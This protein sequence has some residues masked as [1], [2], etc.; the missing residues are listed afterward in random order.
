M[1]GEEIS[2]AGKGKNPEHQP[3]RRGQQQATTCSLGLFP[4]TGQCPQATTVDEFQ[5]RQVQDDVGVAGHHTRER[6][7]DAAA[8]VASSCPRNLTTV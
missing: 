8:S 2:Q 7:S 1:D 4:H 3:L 6:G 5:P